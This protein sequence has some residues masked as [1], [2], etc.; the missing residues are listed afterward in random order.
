MHRRHWQWERHAQTAHQCRQAREQRYHR[1]LRTCFS[2]IFPQVSGKLLQSKWTGNQGQAMPFARGAI[3]GRIHSLRK[4]L[5]AILP[6]SKGMW[7][8]LHLL[9]FETNQALLYRSATTSNL[10]ETLINSIASCA[11]EQDTRWEMR[12]CLRYRNVLVCSDRDCTW[13]TRAPQ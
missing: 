13:H 4:Q 9:Y 10:A 3:V 12:Q 2:D 6:C 11:G 8:Q 5:L 7:P 1:S